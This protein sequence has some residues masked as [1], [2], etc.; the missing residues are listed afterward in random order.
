MMGDDFPLPRSEVRLKFKIVSTNSEWRQGF[1]LRTEGG[2]S[3]TE[4]GKYHRGLVFWE[5]TAPKEYIL[6]C[7]SKNKIVDVRNV[8]DV[9]K[10][11]M[12][13]GINGA[14][15]WF[16]EIPNGRRYYCNDGHFDDDFNDIIF[17][18]TIVD[19]P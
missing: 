2:L 1:N 15:M 4:K 6:Y 14:A 12:D 13:A 18:L 7:R 10:G 8:W 19:D 16:E 9:G 5:D 11:G 17:E 3:I